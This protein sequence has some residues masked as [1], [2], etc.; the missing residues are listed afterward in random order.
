[1]DFLSQSNGVYEG[2]P[3]LPSLYSNARHKRNFQ[4]IVRNVMLVLFIFMLFFTPLCVAAYG[5]SLRDIVLLNL[6]Y[7]TF[8]MMIQVAYSICL[9]FNI[10]INIFPIIGIINALRERYQASN[11]NENGLEIQPLG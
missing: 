1:M 5:S 11:I 8:E 4:G 6:D 9:I 10:S 2:I 7:G 3:L